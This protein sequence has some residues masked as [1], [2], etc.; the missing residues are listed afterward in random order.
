METEISRQKWA[1]LK[2]VQPT[3]PSDPTNTVYGAGMDNPVQNNTWDEAVLFNMYESFQVL[4]L[5]YLP[6][7]GNGEFNK[8]CPYTSTKNRKRGQSLLRPFC[9]RSGIMGHASFL[10][11]KGRFWPIFVGF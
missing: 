1:D 9:T 4:V 8:K 3:L 5:D 2:V 11:T 7:I 6:W 10:G